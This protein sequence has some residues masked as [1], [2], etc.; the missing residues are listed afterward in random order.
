MGG[1]TM[2]AGDA[3]KSHCGL[4][5]RGRG[6][7][8]DNVKHQITHRS[9]PA[10]AG[11]PSSGAA[12]RSRSRVYP[13]VGGGTSTL[14]FDT[15]PLSG[16]SPRGRGNLADGRVR[17]IHQ[18]S[19]PAWAGEP[20]TAE[21]LG[22][23]D[24]VYPRVGGGTI[25]ITVKKQQSVGLSPRGR[26]NQVARHRVHNGQRS[27]PAW[28][29]EPKIL[30]FNNPAKRVYPRVGGGTCST[31]SLRFSSSG[32]S[33]RGRGNRRYGCGSIPIRGSIPAWA[34]EPLPACSRHDTAGVYPRVGGGTAC[35][36]IGHGQVTGLSPR[37]RGN[38]RAHYERVGNGGSIPAWAGEPTLPASPAA[39]AAVYP[40]VGGGTMGSQKEVERS[41]GLSPRGRGNLPA[42]R[43]SLRLS[44]SIPAWAGEPAQRLP[45]V[46]RPQVYP[47]VGGG[48]WLHLRR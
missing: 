1:G 2:S 37:G 12:A 25:G 26:G 47:R 14:L 46:S 11:E 40:R 15:L 42:L 44:R 3:R 13:R 8:Q 4:S 18:G 39:I 16:L 7:R 30:S 27:I 34:G 41:A 36:G 28:A 22:L 20:L 19:I 45:G 17:D 38:L 21:W 43:S 35:V 33:P 48:T 5:P 32:L 24:K 29:G 9:I 10:W 31:Q 6:N 23:G